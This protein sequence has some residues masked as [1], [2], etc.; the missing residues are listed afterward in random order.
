L[1]NYCPL[2]IVGNVDLIDGDKDEFTRSDRMG[3]AL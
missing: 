3:R 1:D 2:E